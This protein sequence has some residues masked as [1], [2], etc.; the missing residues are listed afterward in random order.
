MTAA[1][2]VS[3]EIV[4]RLSR[5][6]ASATKYTLAY[7]TVVKANLAIFINVKYADLDKDILLGRLSEWQRITSTTSLAAH[8]LRHNTQCMQMFTEQ[9]KHSSRFFHDGANVKLP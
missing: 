6:I 5:L 2:C 4:E 9:I 8:Q 1:S 7:A 3:V